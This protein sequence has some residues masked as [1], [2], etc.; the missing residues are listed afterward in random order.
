MVGLPRRRQLGR[1]RRRRRNGRPRRRP[2]GDSFF[3]GHLLLLHRPQVRRR[4]RH[5]ERH[6]HPPALVE[7]PHPL[8][9]RDRAWPRTQEP[10]AV[11]RTRE[12][13]PLPKETPRHQL[14]LDVVD[15]L[16]HGHGLLPH[17]RRSPEDRLHRPPHRR[18]RH[19]ARRHRRRRNARLEI[20]RHPRQGRRRPRR[21]RRCHRR[22]RRGRRGQGLRVLRSIIIAHKKNRP[23]C[24]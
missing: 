18:R 3:H 11:P 4:R 22:R 14:L 17:P 6:V 9:R 20:R 21:R 24:T 2:L 12:G 8:Q 19:Q 10:P 13:R 15:V 7:H 23:R 16:R 5:L 1:L